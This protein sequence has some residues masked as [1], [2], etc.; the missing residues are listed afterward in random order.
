M[1]P[2]AA[3]RAIAPT[4]SRSLLHGAARFSMNIL[5]VDQVGLEDRWRSRLPRAW[6]F[7]RERGAHEVWRLIRQHGVRQCIGFVGRN[8]RYML[9]IAVSKNFDRRYGV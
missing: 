4:R 1:A 7:L 9:A 3:G 8:L 6:R 2:C 5:R